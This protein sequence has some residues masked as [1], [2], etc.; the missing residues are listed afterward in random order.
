MNERDVIERFG[1]QDVTRLGDPARFWLI[2]TAEV[3]LTN[4]VREEILDE[5]ELPHMNCLCGNSSKILSRIFYVRRLQWLLS[6][7]HR[8][9]VG[10]L[11]LEGR[12]VERQIIG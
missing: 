7:Q 5:A 1:E 8:M 3:P 12:I 4:Y 11:N 10:K 9:D 2:P 6:W